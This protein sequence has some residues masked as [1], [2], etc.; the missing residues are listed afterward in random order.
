MQRV[1]HKV[2]SAWDKEGNGDIDYQ[3][4]CK[5]L[6]RV[7]TRIRP[8]LKQK[9]WDE[10]CGGEYFIEEEDLLTFLI[11]EHE[12]AACEGFKQMLIGAAE[13][14]EV[15]RIK[16]TL[17]L[18]AP[19]VKKENFR[20]RS[21]RSAS[22]GN[23]LRIKPVPTR[24]MRLSKNELTN[25]I[26]TSVIDQP[27]NINRNSGTRYGP[28]A[29][30]NRKQPAWKNNTGPTAPPSGPT[31]PTKPISVSLKKRGVEVSDEKSLLYVESLTVLDSSALDSVSESIDNKREE[32]DSDTSESL[33]L[34]LIQLNQH[35][36]IEELVGEMGT[37]FQVVNEVGSA[38]LFDL[39]KSFSSTSLISDVGPLNANYL[40]SQALK[41]KQLAIWTTVISLLADSR[42]KRKRLGIGM[43]VRFADLIRSFVPFDDILALR[44]NFNLTDMQYCTF[45][46]SI[47]A[48]SPDGIFRYEEKLECWTLVYKF[49]K[50]SRD[51]QPSSFALDDSGNIFFQTCGLLYML[52]Y[53]R[54]IPIQ[55]KPNTG[56]FSRFFKSVQC[57]GGLCFDKKRGLLLYCSNDKINSM[58]TRNGSNSVKTRLQLDDNGLFIAFDSNSRVLY[59]SD[60][61]G[62]IYVAT[63]TTSYIVFSFNDT[64]RHGI[65]VDPVT[66]CL[67]I[68]NKYIEELVQG[69]RLEK[70]KLRRICSTPNPGD[71]LTFDPINER[72]FFV[73]S[74][75]KPDVAR[76]GILK[77][78]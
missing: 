56:L 43:S 65:V 39:K 16:F 76:I 68:H 20:N 2:F 51:D 33:D 46:R 18:A 49:E 64:R 1:A 19:Q 66:E 50:V 28:A 23:I 32:S 60:I 14:R 30:V 54:D 47:L 26:S 58:D 70:W 52:P 34:S 48:A 36:S 4:F 55:L 12:N 37:G 38:S 57:T 31:G 77:F 40:P 13:Q 78:R 73:D 22:Q 24:K 3:E 61:C 74:R 44:A 27:S 11:S 25:R 67:L 7:N 45:S 42:R 17:D 71:V 69:M 10:L 9:L 41:K 72:L 29:R 8:N 15:R 53:L 75:P 63:D 21:M 5:G 35:K 59:C 62:T 6:E